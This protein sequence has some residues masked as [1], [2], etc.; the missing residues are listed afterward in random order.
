MNPDP[1]LS[2]GPRSGSYRGRFAPSPTGPLHFGS[3]VTAVGSY[4]EARKA[5]GRWLVRIENLDPPR[6]VPAAAA[7]ML[8]T[9]ER[10]G[11]AWDE[12]VLYQSNRTEAYETA[13]QRLRALDLAYPCSCSRS[14]LQMTE[15][16]ADNGEELRYPGFCQVQPRRS[17][18]PHAYRF[19]AP[20]QAIGFHDDLQGDLVVDLADTIGDFVIK[21][22]DGLFAYQLAVVVDDAAQGITHVVRGA[23]LLMN[24]PRQIALQQALGIA[25]PRY[26]HLPLATDAAGRKLS[27]ATGA[28]AVDE[29]AA[30]KA[31]WKALAFLGLDPPWELGTAPVT[32]LWN[33]AV[34][35]WS[36]RRLAG[37]RDIPAVG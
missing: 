12:E 2:A 4:L 26:M 29:L 25:S 36:P 23:D 37:I 32:E 22:R 31:L 30:S 10:L 18:G 24:T 11:F 21:R 13:L 8:R 17:T 5:G 33:W 15:H 14:E 20:P 3:L 9:L 7:G 34:E 19:R 6:E 35:H 16:M 27:K 1:Q 28:S